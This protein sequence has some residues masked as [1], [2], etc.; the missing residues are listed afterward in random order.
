[1]YWKVKSST[2]RLFSVLRDVVIALFETCILYHKRGLT[3]DS[4][5]LLRMI[6]DIAEKDS[7]SLPDRLRGFIDDIIPS[8]TNIAFPI[9]TCQDTRYYFT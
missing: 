7:S 6:F 2:K 3:I 5:M 1:M 8:E 4:V 9:K